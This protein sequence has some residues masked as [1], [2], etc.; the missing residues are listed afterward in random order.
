MS[1]RN[2]KLIVI[3]A[4][5][6]LAVLFSGSALSVSLN[7]DGRGTAVL[8]YEKSELEPEFSDVSAFTAHMNLFIDSINLA[9]GQKDA[10]VINGI[11]EAGQLY[12]VSIT[13]RRISIIK[14]MGDFAWS[15]FSVAAAHESENQLL[16]ERLAQGNMRLDL[17]RRYEGKAGLVSI[18]RNV[19]QKVLPVAADK[20]VLT[21]EEFIKQGQQ[22]TGGLMYAGY[23]MLD[24]GALKEISISVAGELKFY[25][26]NSTAAGST[27]VI[28][29]AESISA[30]IQKFKPETDG[31]GNPVLNEDGSVRTVPVTVDEDINCFIGYFVFRPTGAPT[32]LILIISGVIIAG[33]VAAGIFSGAFKRFFKSKLF[34][35]IAKY[36]VLYILLLPGLT[37]L[38]VFSYLPMFGIIIAFK[39]YTL[40]EG[41]IGSEWVGLKH[42]RHI[43]LAQDPTI[44]RIFRN[45][46]FISLIRIA[47]NFPVILLFTLMLHTVK[48]RAVKS[49]AQ[50]ISYLPYFISW[51]AVGGMM[52]SILDKDSGMLNKA[53]EV[54]GGTKINWYAQSDAWWMILALSSLWKSM[55]WSTI[56]YMSAL[57]SID[58]ELYDACRID[59]GGMF[60]QAVTVTLP[61]IMNVIMLQL[62]LDSASIIRDNYEQVLAMTRS[63]GA[64]GDTTTVVGGIGFEA[65]LSGGGYS[66]ATALGLIQGIVGLFLVLMTNSIVK[67]SGSEGVL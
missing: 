51:V 63:S 64:I 21:A 31:S 55:G 41:F 19:G 48:N 10:V 33:L 27:L 15:E 12:K 28:R 23:R 18:G 20:T 56:I 43:L 22:D 26:D 62:I 44:Y 66:V 34:A 50:T 16:V 30:Q 45:T 52:F 46:I 32:A 7:E 29:P 9:S 57:S 38:A 53:I 17:E 42:F 60:R 14:G 25:S 67:K 8:S 65:I 6:V 2:K 47:T 59:G 40:L 3:A 13:F 4:L 54:F 35:A 49:G 58:T 1:K 37:F 61:G 36:K 39:D 11:E 24:T 5:A